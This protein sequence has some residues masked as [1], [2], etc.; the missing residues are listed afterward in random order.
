M[1]NALY[2]LAQRVDRDGMS[3][4]VTVFSPKQEQLGLPPVV[5]TAGIRNGWVIGIAFFDRRSTCE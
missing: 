2:P 4:R 1:G 3:V 5:V